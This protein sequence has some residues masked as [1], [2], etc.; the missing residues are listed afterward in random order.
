MNWNKLFH[1]SLVLFQF[2]PI[3]MK[4]DS[5]QKRREKNNSYYKKTKDT[6]KRYY[7]N[8]EKRLAYQKKYDSEHKEQKNEYERKNRRSSAY[9]LKKR[10]QHHSQE[11]H[12]PVLMQ[13]IGQCQECGSKNKLQIHHK[14]YTYRIEDCMLVCLVCHKKLHRIQIP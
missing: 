1:T 7:R 8:R 12:L 9:Y 3:K 4:K 2:F 13:V 6:L 10:I 11:Y 14:K 5:I